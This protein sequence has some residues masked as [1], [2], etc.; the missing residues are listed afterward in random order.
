MAR[1]TIFSGKCVSMCKFLKILGILFVIPIFSWAQEDI[2]IVWKNDTCWYV[3]PS[4]DEVYHP[5][6][7]VTITFPEYTD[8]PYQSFKV[9]WEDGIVSG[10]YA[11]NVEHKFGYLYTK[12]GIYDLKVML[13][14]GADVTGVPDAVYHKKIMNRN[15]EVAFQLSPAKPWRCMEWGGDSVKLVVT[16]HN[17]PP[18]TK[19]EIVVNSDIEKFEPSGE[20][21]FLN[22]WIDDR[23][24]SAWIVALKPTGTYGARVGINLWWE[25]NGV[26]LNT[27]PAK[28]E[29]F[30]A[31][32]TPDL[33][34]IYHFVDSLKEDES[35]DNFKICT[36]NDVGVLWLDTAILAQY[37]YRFISN[38]TVAPQYNSVNNNLFFDIQ[39]F[40]T[41]ELPDDDTAWDIVTGNDSYVDTTRTIKFKKAG[42][43]KMKI[44]AYNQ[45]GFD[46]KDDAHLLFVDSLW[47]DSLK[48]EPTKRYFQVF[49][50][51]KDQLVC[52]QDSVCTGGVAGT[53]TFIDR[54]VRM[55]YDVPPTY[56]F[57][58][59]KIEADGEI[60][61][62]FTTTKKIYKGGSILT[63]G[64]ENAGCDST[65]IIMTLRDTGNYAVTIKRTNEVCDPVTQEFQVFVGD[66]PTSGKSLIEDKLFLD[67]YFEY[68]S[69]GAFYQRCDTFYYT[70]QKD[71]WTMN[72]YAA[73]SVFYYF[74]K[75]NGH[76]DT[77]LNYAASVYHFDTVGNTWNYIRSRAHNYCGWGDEVA[78]NF[79]T[80]T[81]P[82][83][84]LLRDSLPDN[85]S[86]CLK[87]EYDYYLGGVLPENYSLTYTPGSPAYVNGGYLAAGDKVEYENFSDIEKIISVNHQKVSKVGE[88]FVI[89]NKDMKSCYQAY[90]D[91]VYVIATPD[92]P[93]FRD[94]VRYCESQSKLSTEQL[95]DPAKKQFNR[96]EWEW[97][98]ILKSLEQFPEFSYTPGVDTLVYKLSNSA[99]CSVKGKLLFRSMPAPKLE[100]EPA[101]MACLP[102][103]IRDVRYN[104]YVKQFDDAAS[105]VLSVYHTTVSDATLCCR[106]GNCEKLPLT[107]FISDSVR[108]IYVLENESVDR[109]F[110]AGCRLE[111]TVDIALFRP[112]LKI[113]RKDT[114]H[115]DW[116]TYR[117]QSMSGAI[118]TAGIVGNTLRWK[119]EKG[120]G[121]LTPQ[122]TDRLY[123]GS[124]TT[125][126]G[127]RAGDEIRF[128]LFGQTPCGKELHD[129]LVVVVAH[130]ELNG[131]TDTI[132]STEEYPL[133]TKVSSTFIDESS[134]TWKV[135]YPDD[136]AKQGHLS[137]AVGSA[138]KYTPYSGSGASDSVRIYVEGSF[139]E[140]PGYRAGDTIVLR[141]NPAPRITVVSDT[142]IAD[143]R[144]VNIYKISEDWFKAEHTGNRTIAAV[145]RSN[146]GELTED[147]I[148]RFD[149]RLPAG[150]DNR[151]A[152]VIVFV[153]G[154]PGCPQSRQNFTFL[155]FTAPD[156]RFKRP[157]EMCAGD[158][159][160][161]DTIF[162]RIKNFDHYTAGRWTL[163]GDAPQGTFDSDS[164]HYT[165]PV[166][167]GDR[168]LKLE[169]SKSYKAYNGNTYSG[170]LP[171]SHR[172]K[173][174]VH[175][176]PTLILSH[177]KDTLC[178]TQD[179]LDI[180]RA[181][182]AVWPELY[183]DSLLL[184]GLPFLADREY[185]TAAQ[186]GG[187]DR[188]LFSVAQGS[189]TKWREQI[190]DT[191]FLYRLNHM[192]TGD[193]KIGPVC[194]VEQPELDIT[195]PLYAPEAT[196]IR[197]KAQGGSLTSDF[198][199]KF[200]PS[201]QGT[202][203][204]AVTLFVRAPSG[205]GEDS[206]RKEFSIYRMPE[207]ELRADT[208]CR[209]P[210][211]TVSVEVVSIATNAMADIRQVD[212]FRKG[213]TV[214]LGTTLGRLAFDYPVN[215]QDSVAG[216]VELVAKVWAETP[217][218]SRFVYD[219][220]RIALQDRPDI[221]LKADA[222]SVCQGNPIDLSGQVGIGGAAFVQWTKLPTTVGSLDGTVYNPGEYWGNAEFK[223]TAL[224]KYGCPRAEKDIAVS[225][226]YAPEPRVQVS[227]APLCQT[228][229]VH[230]KVISQ[231]GVPSGYEWNFGDNTPKEQGNEAKHAYAGNGTF[232]V[233]L[234]G[235]YG[236]CKRQILLPVPIDEKP[237][238][239]FTP[240]AQVSIGEPV[241]FTSESVPSDVA[242]KW[243]FDNGTALGNL[244][245]H[246]FTGVSGTRRV[247][248]E[249]TTEQ[250]CRD[251]VSHTILAVEK[252]KADFTLKIDSCQGVVEIENRSSRN[253]A[254]VLWD[255]GN[256]TS[257]SS[258]W[259][260]QTQHYAR[261]FADTVYHIKL[262]LENTAGA[263]SLVLPVKMISKLK[264]GFEILPASGN[265]NNLE[266]EL[267]V[268]V[269]GEADRVQVWWGDG[270]YEKWDASVAVAIRKH[271]YTNDTTVVK[272][273]PLILAAENGCEQ[274]TTF[275]VAVPVYPQTVKARV[276]LDD[277]YADECYGAEIGF[278]NKSFGFIPEGYRCEWIF[279]EEGN[280]LTDNRPQVTHVFEKPGLYRVKLKVYDNCNEDTDSVFVRVHGNDSL[281]FEIERGVYC[282]GKEVKMAFVQKGE[283]PFGDFRWEFSNGAVK[284]GR[285][286]AVSFPDAGVQTVRLTATAD[287]CTSATAPR[288]VIVEKSPEPLVVKP[289]VLSGCQP[290]E[291]VFEG[292][293]GT[294]EDAQVLW[295]FKD[296]AF[297]DREV[298]TKIFE[299]AGIY[300]V[301]FRLTTAAGCSDSVNIPVQVLPT[302]QADLKIRQDLFCTESGTFEVS[303]LNLSPERENSAF[304]WKRGDEL[305]SVQSDSVR[306]TVN[307]EFGDI[308]ISL[309]AVHKLSGCVS[310]KTDTVV[311]AHRVKAV[312]ALDV[313]KV[314]KGTPVQFTDHSSNGGYTELNFG[315]GTVTNESSAVYTYE[316][317]GD[318]PV[319]LK[320]SN[321]EG[322]ADSLER[323]VTVHAVPEVNFSWAS[324]YSNTGLPEDLKVPEKAN[325]GMKF[326]NLSYL[327]GSDDTL[328]YRWSFGDGS[329]VS[330]EK[331]P[332]HLYP[333]NG[334]YTV[335][336]YAESKAGCRD[337]VSDVLFISA[338]KGL[339]IPTAFA[340]A[341]SDE[342]VNR[343]QPKGI[344]LYEYKIRVYDNWGTCVWS[345]DKLVDGQPAEWWDGTYN[346][347]PLQGGLYKW[348][349]TALFKDG[350]VWED[351]G[352]AGWVSLIR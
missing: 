204:G 279:G 147:S 34:D 233:A 143:H 330:V 16:G 210:G 280:R 160:A 342:G 232:Q 224:G 309:K 329:G 175:P 226:G 201:F 140:A 173:V 5:N 6:Y 153:D 296:N 311:S 122:G 32:K 264:A 107:S 89:V 261:I 230:F 164:S 137:P 10:G 95:F 48:D 70:L 25:Q 305:I 343:F 13:Y 126:A 105:A 7:N 187:E 242:C 278:E 44:E 308:V 21:L 60:D 144:E 339:Y 102:D 169:V 85:D 262:K 197:W 180:S 56:E 132:C 183:K 291:V 236:Q 51:G 184:N 238:A 134:L 299:T 255:F 33:R 171:V 346:G 84:K 62:G 244:C 216:V 52:R 314:C 26:V 194:E 272:Y 351:G 36:S 121:S 151:Y 189:C 267:H 300:P 352:N 344:G 338:V 49:E 258:D 142:L 170:V 286:V 43:Y 23:P 94:S 74:E 106:G 285:E 282:S 256:G 192:V 307:R 203:E 82:D 100:L 86:L 268:Q 133:W 159:I 154:L 306:L 341:V 42:F 231:P 145:M 99:G 234:T 119:L 135:C 302:P 223:V 337:S 35:P 315:D 15:L 110:Q 128:V 320:V 269:Q 293:N 37:Q 199:P 266:K 28:W 113:T 45:C 146:N 139:A 289:A 112:E 340:P 207:V 75:S 123:G 129:T 1:E 61:A 257:V 50:Q 88:D 190:Q 55:S 212:W 20:P 131:Y 211:Q 325:G 19:Y 111:D 196:G 77:V 91:S 73:D 109:V 163:E 38:P 166:S 101:Y 178:R 81:R 350:T 209:M 248:L 336:L 313:Q 46:P 179:K 4:Y 148:Y 158:E 124:Y 274:D 156:F 66:V 303:C 27:T 284:N 228:D 245:S 125:S 281:D 53:V 254:N 249:V 334:S 168:T 72:N 229:T 58:V 87:I 127:D 318:Y 287:G 319:K 253:Y 225:V 24:D 78:V 250:G 271:R 331:S 324:D 57:T 138:V 240:D 214:L 98:T 92:A 193:F 270:A 76:R 265:C 3:N 29:M 117:F 276:V 2:T 304:E 273:F 12:P 347:V 104:S 83:M 182:L 237:S 177:K 219:T 217:C 39:Y 295:D 215:R 97:N 195:A 167:S 251:T 298:V 185:L 14:T 93:I 205:C 292:K 243:Y 322:C 172:V 198:P 9:E 47:T 335:T 247:L 327:P 218:D 252:P 348:K 188:V 220:V 96:A 349:V 310:E 288:T 186:A 290:F 213:E 222:P 316:K 120:T 69:E 208:V 71:I 54:N 345:S 64:I 174:T 246:I 202:G 321:R 162:D 239:R 116:A 277:S 301:S 283:M 22:T 241:Q 152:D 108:L 317:T 80:R 103:T 149:S 141:V 263:D 161:L 90:K 31:F 136:P 165:A 332:K 150:G 206:L 17:N 181:W 114:L 235:T 275:P 176:E 157:L 155:D 59:K 79:Y 67:Y 65:E 323:T 8:S 115:Y 294:G 312:L 333:N 30:Y 63:G 118:D 260:P 328:R 259:E 130:G 326:T 191:L 200:L 41:D 40:Y 221:R 227:T 18:G 297:S 11:T 68:N